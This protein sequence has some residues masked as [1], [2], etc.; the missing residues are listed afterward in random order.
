MK[1]LAGKSAIVTGAGTG[2][3]FEVCKQLVINGC[4]VILND[5]EED[6]ANQAAEKL[7]GNPGKC[8]PAVGDSS[9]IKT[10]KSFVNAAVTHF[11]KLDIAIANAGITSFGDFFSFKEDMFQ[12]LLDVNLR[13]TFFLVQEASKYMKEHDGGSIVMT[14]SV[15]GHQAVKNLSAYGM[16]KAAIEMLSKALVIDLSPH[17]ININ[18]VA[19]GATVTERTLLEEEDYEGTW[20]KLIPMN[21]ACYP[22]DIANAIMFLA[23]D[24]ARQI[25]GQTIVVDGGWTA[26]SPLPE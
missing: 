3:G 21:R 26:T 12:R 15:T 8:V 17:Q 19:P 11:G 16:S 2:I 4:H 18:C 14:S 22:I 23:S 25:T 9:D 1:S 24:E 13:G 5:V 6:V 7:K 20:S 10:I